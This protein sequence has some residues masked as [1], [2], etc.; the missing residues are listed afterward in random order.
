MVLLLFA[1]CVVF[2]VSSEG[3][4]HETLLWFLDLYLKDNR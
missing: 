3:R 2:T 1:V 4:N